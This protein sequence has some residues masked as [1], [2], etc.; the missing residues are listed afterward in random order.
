M[1]TGKGGYDYDACQPDLYNAS[2]TTTLIRYL[3]PMTGNHKSWK[4]EYSIKEE[5]Y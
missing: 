1:P 5:L 4:E 3:L 2:I